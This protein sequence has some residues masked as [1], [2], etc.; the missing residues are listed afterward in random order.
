MTYRKNLVEV[1]R[2]S[3]KELSSIM[4]EEL[5]RKTVLMI[6]REASKESETSGL[7][8][9]SKSSMARFISRLVVGLSRITSYRSLVV[10]QDCGVSMDWRVSESAVFGMIL[11]RIVSDDDLSKLVS[12]PEPYFESELR[13]AHEACGIQHDNM[14]AHAFA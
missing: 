6:A 1:L 8:V 3:V 14:R 9:S 12:Q 7:M 2:T 5:A 4:N 10:M 11:R 13:V